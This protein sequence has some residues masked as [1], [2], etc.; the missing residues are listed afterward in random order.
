MG[1]GNLLRNASFPIHTN[2]ELNGKQ[3]FTVHEFVL[4]QTFCFE[5]I[6]YE[7]TLNTYSSDGTSEK[8]S[9]TQEKN[10]TTMLVCVALRSPLTLHRECL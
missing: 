10:K 4:K 2:C 8:L 6:Q 7:Q 9:G 5:V 3:L 1:G